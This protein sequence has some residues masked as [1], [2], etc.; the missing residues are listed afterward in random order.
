LKNGAT[1]VENREVLLHSALYAGAPAAVE[2]FRNARE[3]LDEL[4]LS[5]P[6][7]D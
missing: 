4:G 6:D 5:I 7:H 3:V 2:A 1:I